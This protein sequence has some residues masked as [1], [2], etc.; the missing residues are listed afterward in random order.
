MI[1]IFQGSANDIP[2]ER[3]K[4]RGGEFRRN[5]N[6][7]KLVVAWKRVSSRVPTSEIREN[8]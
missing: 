2:E 6:T 1:R 3:N 8:A 5:K 7:P 4:I